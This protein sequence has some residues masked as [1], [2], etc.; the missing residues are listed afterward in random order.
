MRSVRAIRILYIHIRLNERP[1][2][3]PEA[4]SSCAVLDQWWMWRRISAGAPEFAQSLRAALVRARRGLR[5]NVVDIHMRYG[6]QGVGPCCP[7]VPDPTSRVVAVPRQPS[8]SEDRSYVFC[9]G[10]L[11]AAERGE[12][13]LFPVRR[14]FP[15][16]WLGG[17]S[18]SLAILRDA[19]L[20]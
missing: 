20:I 11:S 18:F 2:Q 3:D 1:M 7:N 19:K 14:V 8:A 16:I 15:F 5:L 10:L 13:A 6:P 17:S 4:G 12:R 9:C